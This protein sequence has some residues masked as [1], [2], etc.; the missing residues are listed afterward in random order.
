MEGLWLQ[1]ILLHLKFWGG[2]L[3]IKLKQ[4]TV[5]LQVSLL[6]E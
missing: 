2:Q 6:V 3:M 1:L 5:Q 4:V